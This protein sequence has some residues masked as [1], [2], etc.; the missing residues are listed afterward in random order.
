MIKSNKSKSMTMCI[1]ERWSRNAG[2]FG[3]VENS[4]T[5]P[6]LLAADAYINN[7]TTIL[8]MRKLECEFG[9]ADFLEWDEE[10]LVRNVVADK[11]ASG[12]IIYG[13]DESMGFDV[14]NL[15]QS[16]EVREHLRKYRKF[17]PLEQDIIIRNS[18]YSIEQKLEFMKQLLDDVR[19]MNG[20]REEL[21][22]LEERVK[23]Y[24]FVVNFIHNPGNDVIYMAQEE[25][26]G[27]NICREDNDYRL[28]EKIYA[29]TH[30]FRK[31]ADLITYWEGA[32]G[33]EYTVCVDMVLLSEQGT[34]YNA[35]EIVQPVWFYMAIDLEGKVRIRKF[36]IDDKWFERKG[37][38]RD[39]IRDIYDEFHSPLPF[40]H[41]SRIKLKTPEMCEPVYGF[42]ESSEDGNGC[43]FHFLYVEDDEHDF[44]AVKKLMEDNKIWGEY[45]DRPV[46]VISLTYP[47]LD[48]YDKFLSY[49]W[50]ERAQD[51]EEQEN[52]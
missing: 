8:F 52:L 40:E 45:N 30:Y 1:R 37:F 36:E 43:W 51:V 44:H 19:E 4:W 14:Y 16:K 32:V 9:M 38:S 25:T 22:L 41:G 17:K 21:E 31:F 12:K 10:H 46:D 13:K 39:C 42:L 20:E 29:D 48:M 23:M 27:Y 50:I 26:R 3:A 28:S 15:I 7:V 11:M 6:P 2:F 35:D 33:T 34:K 5:P 24:E 47:Q 18:Y 49:D